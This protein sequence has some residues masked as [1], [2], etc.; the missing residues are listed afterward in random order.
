VLALALAFAGSQLQAVAAP[1]L[2]PSADSARVRIVHGIADAGPLDVYIDGAIALIGMEFP[3][4]SSDVRLTGGEHG[5]AVVPTGQDSDAAIASGTIALQPA[6]LAYVPLLGTAASASVGLFPVDNRPLDAGLARFRIISGI[7]DA[8]EIV[9][10]FAAGEAISE[11]LAFG[12]ATEYAAV[13]AGTYDLDL[14]DAVS[15]ASLLALPQTPLPEGATTDIILVGQVADGT[16]QSVVE[17]VG[18]EVTP[19]TGQTAQVISGTCASPG[20]LVSEIGLVRPGQGEAVG[21][22]DAPLVS[23]GFGLAGVAFATLIASPHAVTVAEGGDAPADFAA[24]G[25]IGGQLTDTGALVIA[26]AEARSAEPAGVAVLASS[27][28]DPEATGVSVFLT[29]GATAAI[30]VATPAA[31]SEES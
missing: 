25:N 30:P 24:C 21:A 8:G 12:D 18:I 1:S 5:F 19:A 26:L 13:E 14:V 11:P 3:E 15:G 23:Q 20:D 31:V 16:L 9:P 7:P 22:P 2:Q 6:T 28:E 17:A 10:A 27:I 29:L 4:V